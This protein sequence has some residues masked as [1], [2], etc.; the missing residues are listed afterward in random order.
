MPPSLDP[1]MGAGCCGS[2]SWEPLWGA[3]AWAAGCRH[4]RGARGM[5]PPPLPRRELAMGRRRA[6][7]W[8]PLGSV[9]R[10]TAATI[11]EH[12]GCKVR[13]QLAAGRCWRSVR[14]AAAGAGSGSLCG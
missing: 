13:G 2:Q 6:G 1:A 11:E 12:V 3:G 5:P 10:A 8:P 14:A 7:N 9:R 4:C